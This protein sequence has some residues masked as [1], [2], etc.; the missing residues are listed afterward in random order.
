MGQ[1]NEKVLLGRD[2]W[3]FYKEDVDHLLGTGFLKEKG[4][5]QSHAPGADPLPALIQFNKDLAGMGIHLLVLPIPVKPSIE[6]EHLGGF[7]PQDRYPLK[8]PST[9]LFFK[10][11]EESGI[12]YLDL[13]QAMHDAKASSGKDQFLKTDTHWTPDTM[14]MAS[15][16]VAGKIRSL[17][18]VSSPPRIAPQ[19][20]SLIHI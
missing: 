5:G 2:G 13:T 6:A 18:A 20:L 12:D 10:K 16:I 7:D 4:T 15:A 14:E 19:S 17:D 1:G 11:L 8:N 3:L 9:D